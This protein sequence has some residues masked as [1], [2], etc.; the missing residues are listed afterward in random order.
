MCVPTDVTAVEV[1]FTDR[2]TAVDV[3]ASRFSM[4]PAAIAA[5][6]AACRGKLLVLA[7]HGHVGEIEVRDEEDVEVAWY[8]G[9]DRT[10]GELMHEDIASS[11]R[12][13][14]G[15]WNVRVRVEDAARGG[16]TAVDDVIRVQVPDGVE[17]SPPPTVEIAPC[18]C[19]QRRID[20]GELHR[21]VDATE[22]AVTEEAVVQ[23]GVAHVELHRI[24][25]DSREG[26][27]IGTKPSVSTTGHGNDRRI[28]L[29]LGTEIGHDR[30]RE[31]H[32]RE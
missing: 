31:G 20:A 21:D 25:V 29:R 4:H 18:R 15:E 9:A 3:V 32:C 16:E 24:Q 14:R 8:L 13:V 26:F 28:D 7:A 2:C 27:V 1:H 12:E 19:Q 23:R 11:G 5:A 22:D 10:E 30:D 6:P 17:V